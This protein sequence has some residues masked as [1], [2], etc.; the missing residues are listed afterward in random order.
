MLACDKI[1]ISTGIKHG[2]AMCRECRLQPIFGTKWECSECASY[3]LCST[4]YHGDKH[5]LRHKFFRVATPDRSRW[6]VFVC[7]FIFMHL[8]HNNTFSPISFMHIYLKIYK[9]TLHS[10]MHFQ[11]PYNTTG[12][13]PWGENVND[14]P[15]I[16]TP[17]V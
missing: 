7:S 1:Y 3:Q 10:T 8:S 17:L 5:N 2:G 13:I 4:C 15:N 11:L 6:I 16:Q 9:Y 12:M 14:Y